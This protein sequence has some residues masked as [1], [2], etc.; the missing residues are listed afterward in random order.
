MRRQVNQWAAVAVV[1]ALAAGMLACAGCK[2]VARAAASG[3]VSPAEPAKVQALVRIL[4][5]L[6]RPQTNAD[7]RPGL[8]VG[9]SKVGL[10]PVRSLQRLARTTSW[11]AKV[12]VVPMV[13]TSTHGLP[14]NSRRGGLGLSMSGSGSSCCETARQVV[15]GM[16]L[17]GSLHPASLVMV[18]PDGVR[19]IS[20]A[21]GTR[22]GRTPPPVA[23]ER[24]RSN[25]AVVRLKRTFVAGSGNLIT[26]YDASGGVIKKIRS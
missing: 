22:P 7:R 2:L 23:N 11:G 9:S 5:V 10:T 24:V 3:P 25:V 14:L 19:R 18:V 8:F 16:A 4:G 1:V 6:R 15:A 17:T 21:L 20:V 26:W 12:Y 13:K